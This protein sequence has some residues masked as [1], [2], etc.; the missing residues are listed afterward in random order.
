MIV[1]QDFRMTPELR[2]RLLFAFY[3]PSALFSLAWAVLIPVLPVY[4]SELTNEYFIV[5]IILSATAIGRV[6]GSIPS[7]FLL[8]RAGIKNTLITGTVVTLIP[9]L[10]LFFVRNL[11]LTVALLFVVGIGLS[12]FGIARHTYVSVVIPLE[13]RGRAISLL[14]GV[15]RTGLFIGPIIGGWVGGTFGLPSAFLAFFAIGILA[16]LSVMRFMRNLEANVHEKSDDIPETVSFVK[17][18]NENRGIITA[19]GLG[20]W[21]VSVTREGW[22]VLIPLYAANVL[23]LEIE[24]IGLVMGIGAA[25]DMIFF[26]VSG[27]LMDKF[28]RKWAIVPSFVLQGIGIA[29]ILLAGNA[30]A[31]TVF[32]AFIGFGNG[33]SSGTMMTTGADLAPVDNRSQFLS[34]WHFIGDMGAVS[35]PMVVGAVAQAFVI[36]MSITSIAGA[37]FAA[38]LLFAFFV[39]ETLKRRKTKP[40]T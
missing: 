8:N 9:V 10:A 28:G 19:A 27:F 36:Q 6:V 40:A 13:I 16:L 23:G 1:A 3:L 24:T 34:L 39:P 37:G 12:I 18:V 14:G 17:M 11:P 31:L 30:F 4:A 32:A 26:P 29:L 7:S 25:F 5:G 22:R 33:L 15:F 2:K 20:Q 38:A 21:L 35:G